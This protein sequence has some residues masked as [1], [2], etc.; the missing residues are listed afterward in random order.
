M[1]FLGDINSIHQRRRVWQDSSMCAKHHSL[2]GSFGGLCTVA[3]FVGITNLRITGAMPVLARY[4]FAPRSPYHRMLDGGLPNP[5]S[6]GALWFS[7]LL[8]LQ[9]HVASSA[10]VRCGLPGC[11]RFVRQLD[12]HP[13]AWEFRDP[14]NN[15]TFLKRATECQHM[16]K[17]VSVGW[18]TNATLAHVHV[19]KCGGTAIRKVNMH[20]ANGCHVTSR[21]IRTKGSS[22]ANGGGTEGSLLLFAIVRH[23]LDRFVSQFHHI[24]MNPGPEQNAGFRI[25]GTLPTYEDLLAKAQQLQAAAKR[26]SMP[27]WWSPQARWLLDDSLRMNVD[28]LL[29]FESFA[30]DYSQ[31]ATISNLQSLDKD[32]IRAHDHPHWCKF[33]NTTLASLIGELYAADFT[34]LSLLYKPGVCIE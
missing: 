31:L 21:Q 34:C 30:Q 20:Q 13:A 15:S 5:P 18:G 33:I 1:P 24:W 14:E 23:P 9:P 17:T 19:P 26:D 12:Q 28:F 29:Q 16:E 2:V 32:K 25:H 8:A 7:A 10:L 4:E 22:R 11:G 27:W 6:V 3:L